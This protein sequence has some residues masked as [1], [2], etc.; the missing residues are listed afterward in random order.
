MHVEV[1]WSIE[2]LYPGMSNGKRPA[3]Q[4]TTRPMLQENEE[5]QTPMR[6]GI[7]SALIE[8]YIILLKYE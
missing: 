1:L 8:P 4:Q 3:R 6:Q 5:M 7:R 2:Q